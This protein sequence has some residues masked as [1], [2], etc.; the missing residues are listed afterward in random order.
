MLG[1]RD[2]SLMDL[3]AASNEKAVSPG[4]NEALLNAGVLLSLSLTTR[5]WLRASDLL[6]LAQ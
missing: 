5:P 2:D 3:A 4:A 1:A 6:T